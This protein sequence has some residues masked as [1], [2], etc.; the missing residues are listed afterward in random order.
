MTSKYI[1]IDR[2][3]ENVH[4]DYGFELDWI[5]CVE[6]IGECLDLIGAP[7]TYV[8]KA[9]DG[10]EILGHDLPITITENRGKLP[11][12]MLSLVQAFQNKNG[13]WLP[14][15]VS[16]DNSHISYRCNESIDYTRE[17]EITYKLNNNHIFTSFGEGEVILVYNANPTDERGFPMIPD[18]IKFIKAC[19]AYIADKMVMKLG[20]KGVAI[21]P[22][23]ELKIEQELA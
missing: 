9:T 23:I 18:N 2:I 20:L 4:R 15:R 3:L 10:N 8:E 17:T 5:H 22:R 14:M 19:Q 21:N 12:D 1:K 16:T 11:C 13:T 6:W 7:R